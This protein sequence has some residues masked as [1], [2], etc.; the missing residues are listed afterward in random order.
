LEYGAPAGIYAFITRMRD[1][2]I[3]DRELDTMIKDNPAR[4]LGLPAQ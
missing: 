4:L 1:R 3:T 2:G